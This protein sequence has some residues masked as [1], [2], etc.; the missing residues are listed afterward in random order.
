MKR[1]IRSFGFAFK[2]IKYTALTQANFRIHLV[3][4]VLVTGL[5]LALHISTADWQW[6]IMS[7]SLIHI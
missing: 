5:G 6:I 7:L 4:I 2:G 3:A 1:L